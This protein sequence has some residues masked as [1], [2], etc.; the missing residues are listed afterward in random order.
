TSEGGNFNGTVFSLT[1]AGTENVIYQ[2]A[3]APDGS[4][5]VGGV[6][7]DPAGDLFGTT[8]NG[9]ANGH[10]AVFDIDTTGHEHLLYSF[11]GGSDGQNPRAGLTI[12]RAGAHLYGTT[13]DGG[14][15]GSGGSQGTVFKITIATGKETVLHRF[16]YNPFG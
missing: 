12:D 9:G 13:R 10:G 5:P 2:F 4:S 6:V 3:G 15:I 16:A 1:T 8:E 7:A 11:K 14:G